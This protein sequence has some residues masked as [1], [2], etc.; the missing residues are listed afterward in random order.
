MKVSFTA[1]AEEELVVTAGFYA[2]EVSAAVGGAFVD[3]VERA[4][5][6]L[7]ENPSMGREWQMRTRRLVLRRFPFNLIYRVVGDE[8]QIIAV[9]HQRRKPGYWT[10]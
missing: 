7:Q 5:R 9:A 3:E 6:L 4:C 10:T 2:K 8:V 1:Q